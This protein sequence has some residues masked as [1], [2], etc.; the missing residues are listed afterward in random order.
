[1]DK[2]LSQESLDKLSGPWAVTSTVGALQEACRMQ[3]ELMKYLKEKFPDLSRAKRRL[4]L[5]QM[6]KK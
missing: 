2:A 4:L 5:N 1:M 6:L 3:R